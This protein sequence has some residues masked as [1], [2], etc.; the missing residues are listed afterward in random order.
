[1]EVMFK[2]QRHS[3]FTIICRNEKESKEIPVHKIIL[4]ARSPVFAAMLEPHTE[5]AKTNKVVYEDIDY[6]VC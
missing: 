3:D 6:E 5:E 4:S 1:M 2:E